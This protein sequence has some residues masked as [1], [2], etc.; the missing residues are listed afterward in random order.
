MQ[1]RVGAL[2]NALFW[3]QLIGHKATIKTTAD[4]LKSL[5][6]GERVEGIELDTQ[7]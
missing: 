3:D 5:R 2:Q 1:V 4:K 6:R 7:G